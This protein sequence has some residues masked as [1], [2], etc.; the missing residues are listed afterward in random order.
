MNPYSK[1]PV[2]G[3]RYLAAWGL[4]MA[5]TA[6]AYLGAQPIAVGLL[7][8]YDKAGHFAAYSVFTVLLWLAAGGRRPFALLCAV[9]LVG[10]VDECYQS[11]LP[12]RFADVMDLLT[13]ITA[14]GV[15]LLLL[16]RVPHDLRQRLFSTTPWSH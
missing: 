12:G 11:L 10:S 8:A 16:A 9:A 13:D 15:T 6:Y 7:G 2:R 1:S 3:A 14:G 4:L 5:I